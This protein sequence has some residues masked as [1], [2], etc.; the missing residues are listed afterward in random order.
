[1]LP[2]TT[3]S[4]NMEGMLGTQ[5]AILDHEARIVD[6]NGEIKEMEGAWAPIIV[7]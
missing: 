6:K 7:G 5:A 3:P 1:M 2:P 4:W